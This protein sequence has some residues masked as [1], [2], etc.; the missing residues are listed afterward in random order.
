MKL[1]R[2]MCV[3]TVLSLLSIGPLMV[4][5]EGKGTP[6][7]A[8]ATDPGTT[9]WDAEVSFKGTAALDGVTLGDA[10]TTRDGNELVWVSRDQKV[11]LGYY[12]DAGA[13]SYDDIW[14]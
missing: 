5:P 10:D 6:T 9:L 11:Y 1:Q 13:F 2:V 4:L 8:G 7:R 12:T 3:L 14:T